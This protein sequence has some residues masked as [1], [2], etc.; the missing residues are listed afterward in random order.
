MRSPEEVRH[1]GLAVL[2]RS[3]GPVDT[4]RFLQQFDRGQGDYTKDRDKIL[5]HPQLQ[6][7][8]KE[9]ENI[10]LKGTS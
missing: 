3:L 8:V 4:L 7:V 2:A 5:G 10:S 1:L 6:E 9:L